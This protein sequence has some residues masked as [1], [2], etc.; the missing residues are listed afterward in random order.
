MI[1]DECLFHVGA[2]K[3]KIFL[4]FATKYYTKQGFGIENESFENVK[5]YIEQFSVNDFERLLNGCTA[6]QH[7][8]TQNEKPALYRRFSVRKLFGRSVCIRVRTRRVVT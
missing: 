1:N 7:V 4:T 3:I 2:K 6:N 5:N 8:S